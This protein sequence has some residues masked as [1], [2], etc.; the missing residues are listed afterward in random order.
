MTNR[1]STITETMFDSV[2]AGAAGSEAAGLRQLSVCST[3]A[4]TFQKDH[5]LITS[6]RKQLLGLTQ[7]ADVHLD[8]TH[9]AGDG[10]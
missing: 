8:H 4:G 6:T 9:P 3:A 7:E 1:Y 10:Y 5:D 2:A